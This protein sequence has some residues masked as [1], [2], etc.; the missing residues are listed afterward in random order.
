MR[1]VP[2]LWTGT[3]QSSRDETRALARAQTLVPP[4]ASLHGQGVR[5]SFSH[6]LQEP[7]AEDSRQR[8]SAS[9]AVGAVGFDAGAEQVVPPVKAGCGLG[10]CRSA[11]IADAGA[12]RGSMAAGEAAWREAPAGKKHGGWSRSADHAA[13]LSRPDAVEERE[14]RPGAA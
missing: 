9:V 5:S 8:A 4:S 12:L 13:A 3:L 10:P 6:T 11:C 2:H 7:G 14:A 1:L